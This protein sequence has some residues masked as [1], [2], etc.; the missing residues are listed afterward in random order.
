MA[1]LKITTMGIYVMFY[2]NKLTHSLT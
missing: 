2:P 1:S